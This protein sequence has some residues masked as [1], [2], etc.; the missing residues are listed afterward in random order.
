M[1]PTMILD[2]LANADLYA[3]VHPRFAAAFRFLREA[4]F[5]K[6][7]DGEHEIDGRNLFVVVEAVQGRGR[8]GSKLEAHRRYI[9][10]QVAVAGADE[11]GLKPVAAC[12]DVELD[13]D[14]GHDCSLFRDRPENWI[15]LPAGSFVV[16]FPDDGHAPLATASPVRK[17][18]VKVLIDG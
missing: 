16:F 14:E 7:A 11:I 3:P 9:D 13:Y 5:T 1:E 10:I 4:D 18:V 6:L 8:A 2:R 17:A 12:R 15:A